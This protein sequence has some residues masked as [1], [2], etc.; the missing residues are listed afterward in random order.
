ME[1]F[2]QKQ[3]VLILQFARI[4]PSHY[5]GFIVKTGFIVIVAL[6]IFAVSGQLELT[7]I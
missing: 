4:S 6:A 7:N 3:R 5:F 1:G 2:M